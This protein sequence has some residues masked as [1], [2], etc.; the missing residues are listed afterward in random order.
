MSCITKKPVNKTVSVGASPLVKRRSNGGT[1][2]AIS[3]NALT[4]NI[5]ISLNTKHTSK[6]NDK[7]CDKCNVPGGSDRIKCQI[8]RNTY[9]AKC[10]SVTSN[11]ISEIRVI[12]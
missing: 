3:A 9:H 8:C 6:P 5:G 11:W 10:V 2:N 7:I 12:S 4:K 1:I